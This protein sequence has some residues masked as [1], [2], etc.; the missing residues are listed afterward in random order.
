M[1]TEEDAEDSLQ[2]LITDQRW[3][4]GKNGMQYDPSKLDSQAY[5]MR[6]GL[7]LTCRGQAPVQ[8]FEIIKRFG[9]MKREYVPV[10]R[11]GMQQQLRGSVDYTAELVEDLLRRR[12]QAQQGVTSVDEIPERSGTYN[13][14]N[15]T[16]FNQTSGT[17]NNSN[18]HGALWVG[19]GQSVQAS[20]QQQQPLSCRQTETITIRI[21]AGSLRINDIAPQSN[22]CVV[23]SDYPNSPLRIGDEIISINDIEYSSMNCWNDWVSLLQITCRV[24]RS[25][26][27]SRPV[28]GGFGGSGVGSVSAQSVNHEGGFGGSGVGAVSNQY[29]NHEGAF[30]GSGG[31]AVSAQYG[32]HE[33][34][35]VGGSGVGSASPD[36][37]DISY[38]SGSSASSPMYQ[39]SR[40]PPPADDEG[41]VVDVLAHLIAQHV[42]KETGEDLGPNPAEALRTLSVGMSDDISVLTPVTFLMRD[43]LTM[44]T[45]SSNTSWRSA[46]QERNTERQRLVEP[47]AGLTAKPRV[48]RE[49]AIEVDQLRDEVDTFIQNGQDREMIEYVCNA[50][51]DN[52]LGEQSEEVALFCFTKLRINARLSSKFKKKIAKVDGAIRTI[53]ETLTLFSEASADVTLDGCGLVWL[54]CMSD[55]DR[56]AVVESGGVESV[57]NCCLAQME[58]GEV[59]TL[60]MGALK[61]LAF[62][63][64]AKAIIK[65][66]DGMSIA[67][68]VMNENV[69]LAKIQIEGCAVLELLS[70][71]ASNEVVQTIPINYVVDAVLDSIIVHPNSVD[72]AEAAINCLTTF[73]CNSENVP[74]IEGN[75]KARGALETA[76]KNHPR[77]LGLP[78]LS[79]LGQLTQ[80]SKDLAESRVEE[81]LP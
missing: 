54:L 28:R 1:Q 16:N 4:M 17:H 24:D 36:D 10:N 44:N 49:E 11:P 60:A 62:D 42:K 15:T 46:F 22:K 71:D 18:N 33:V 21:P 78:L 59:S 9:G 34:G 74:T 69:T 77:E 55:S 41:T 61:A 57:L 30:G 58:N 3:K 12:M 14:S 2:Q 48:I 80:V 19:P 53:I 75:G 67:F 27:V 66:M 81:R 65:C 79:L 20:I 38:S 72:V 26:L 50:L 35:V 56:R 63:T 8:L 43:D 45:A 73:A 23:V 52:N 37:E 13:N 31:G 40:E 6:K 39:S 64:E 51:A 32:N 47:P 70:V 25:A 29:G 5:R 68:E 76:F 7:C